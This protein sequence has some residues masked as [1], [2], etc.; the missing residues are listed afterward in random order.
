HAEPVRAVAVSRDG[1]RLA[2]ASNDTTVRLWDLVA[3]RQTAVLRGH[4]RVVGAV[5]LSP[6]GRTVASGS[7]DGTIK[8]WDTRS[9][10]ERFSVGASA[11][12]A[13][14]Q[15]PPR[16]PPGAQCP[17]RTCDREGSLLDRDRL[18]PRS[19]AGEAA[20]HPDAVDG[21]RS[22]AGLLG[23]RGRCRRAGPPIHGRTL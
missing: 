19:P 21:E 2:T 20:A 7:E 23:D 16:P 4:K 14:G 11:G 13:S 6:D 3:R 22:P 12:L 9:G 10:R 17:A 18:E 15:R 8:V 1:R 5:A